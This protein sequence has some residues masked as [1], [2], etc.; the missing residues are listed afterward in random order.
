MSAEEASEGIPLR[1]GFDSH[2]SPREYGF[3]RVLFHPQR[4]LPKYVLTLRAEPAPGAGFD[5]SVEKLGPMDAELELAPKPK[6]KKKKNNSKTA[7][8][9]AKNK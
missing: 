9:A 3:E 7:T 5:E 1:A 2:L 6:S 4:A 8:K